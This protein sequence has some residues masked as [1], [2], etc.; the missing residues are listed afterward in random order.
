MIVYYVN[1]NT[2]YKGP[3]DIIDSNRQHII[4]VGDVCL[5]DTK[6]GVCF[7]LVTNSDNSWNACKQVGVGANSELSELGNT[8]LF[9]FDGLHKRSG[10][11]PLIVQ[12]S[13]CFREKVIVDF[14]TNAKDILKYKTDFWDAS[15]FVQFFASTQVLLDRNT[16]RTTSTQHVLKKYP[17]YFAKYFDDDLLRVLNESLGQGKSIKE[18]YVSIR[19]QYPSA[20]RNAMMT[21]LLENPGHTIYDKP[22]V[23]SEP[24]KIESKPAPVEIQREIVVD[25]YDS[26]RLSNEKKQEL[27]KL[28]NRYRKGDSK[29]FDKIVQDNQKLVAVIANTYKGHG[30]DYEDLLQEGTI[31]LI[32]AVERYDPNRGVAFP[33]YAKW[34]IHRYLI[35]AL[36]NL[37]SMVRIPPQHMVLYRKVRK[38]IERYEQEHGYEPSPSEIDIGE[39]IDPESLAYLS[40]LPD[41]LLELTTLSNDLDELPSS[42]STDELLMK[43]SQSH[44][45]NSILNRLKSREAYILRCVY[46]IGEKSESLSVIG[47][48]L[49]LTRER[50]RQIAEKAVKKLRGFMNLQKASNDED[51]TPPQKDGTT[52]HE[53]TSR[54]KKTRKKSE[55][56]I[57]PI[58]KKEIIGES[59][60][61]PSTTSLQK[62]VELQILTKKQLKQCYKRNLRTIDDVKKI[63]NKYHLTPDSTR[64]TK[65]TLDMWFSI[66]RL[67]ENKG[68]KEFFIEQDSDTTIGEDANDVVETDPNETTSYGINDFFPLFGFT[69]GKTTWRQA[70][71]MGCKVKTLKN[72]PGRVTHI[73]EASFWDHDGMGVFTSLSWYED[74]DEKDFPPLWKSKGFSWDNS[75]DEWMDMFRKSGFSITIEE[76]PCQKEY[77][78]RTTLHAEFKALSADGLLEFDLEFDFGEKGYLTSSPNTLF[79]IYVDYLGVNDLFPL[80]GVTLGKTTWKQAMELGGKDIIDEDTGEFYCDIENVHFGYNGDIL[81]DIYWE[82]NYQDFPDLW[83]S[84]GFSWNNSYDE[85]L[86]LFQRLGCEI[87]I[88]SKPEQ[89]INDGRITLSGFFD[90][91]SPDG[92]LSFLMDFRCGEKGYYT[93]SPNTLYSITV[94][95]HEPHIEK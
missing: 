35:D 87:E 34:W 73:G 9:T 43:E 75:Y 20:F 69:P 27:K 74:E 72:R 17:T 18:A 79:S 19:D 95:Y 23:T 36:L 55:E 29:A 66:T 50:V 31:G 92:T 4:K 48:R 11:I 38:S 25:E 70:E 6:D 57:E 49:G 2:K 64:F 44:F 54:A 39:D 1:R 30:V 37:K 45:I 46:G 14:F 77:S 89:E 83:K 21:F 26:F 16:D 51:E 5:R 88:V 76:Q 68:V 65:Y 80:F 71:E 24:E 12:M 81:T 8:L 90:A 42:V 62:L 7:L 15:L 60:Y 82:I 86:G 33:F 63:I 61:L 47:E 84:K 53:T 58:I 13:H 56:K 40:S 22:A 94:Y 52:A 78:G 85:W 91:K 67:S 93:S 10:N 59:H 32:K 28:F 3:Y 41:D